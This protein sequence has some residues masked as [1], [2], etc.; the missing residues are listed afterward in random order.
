MATR[1]LHRLDRL[2]DLGSRVVVRH[3]D[4][5]DAA[6]RRDAELVDDLPGVVV[7]GPD[8]DVL[9]VSSR[10]SVSGAMPATVKDTVGT[11]SRPAPG[12]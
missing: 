4:A 1:R 6:V 7:A 8:E 10:A 11:R 12:R 3:A 5:D 2:V 9:G